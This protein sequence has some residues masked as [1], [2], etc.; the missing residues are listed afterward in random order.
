MYEKRVES[1]ALHIPQKRQLKPFLFRFFS[2][3][4]KTIRV[5]LKKHIFLTHN[6]TCSL[7]NYLANYLCL[8]IPLFF[9]SVCIF[10]KFCQHT[11]SLPPLRMN[12]FLTWNKF[13]FWTYSPNFD[14]SKISWLFKKQL[15]NSLTVYW[16]KNVFNNIECKIITIESDILFINVKP[17]VFH[18]RA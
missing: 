2:K 1:Y 7:Q 17:N 14:I 16:K 3:W 5:K 8:R 4:V 18:H 6:G 10:T 15:I 13:S 9:P 12:E 11:L